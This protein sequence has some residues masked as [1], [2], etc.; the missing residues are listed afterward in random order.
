[1]NEVKGEVVRFGSVGTAKNPEELFAVKAGGFAK[2][3]LNSKMQN[4]K[5]GFV[6]ML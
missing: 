5:Y 1:M 4:Y 2:E 3:I 6:I